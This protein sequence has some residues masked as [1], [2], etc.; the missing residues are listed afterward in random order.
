[1]HNALLPLDEKLCGCPAHTCHG[2][3][4]C[5]ASFPWARLCCRLPFS[6]GIRP[7]NTSSE[8]PILVDPRPK[9]EQREPNTD[10]QLVGD[11]ET[12]T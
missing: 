10:I 8:R 11:P 3:R 1:L 2:T 9:A 6:V 12:Y 4:N 7:L 5:D